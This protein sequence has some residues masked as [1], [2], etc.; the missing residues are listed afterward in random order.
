M[1][2]DVAEE[3]AS[4]CAKS[5]PFSLGSLPAVLKL[6]LSKRWKLLLDSCPTSE[7]LSSITV[8]KGPP[9]PFLLAAPPRTLLILVQ[10]FG[11]QFNI[12]IAQKFQAL[13]GTLHGC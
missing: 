10:V 7:M 8:S 6:P 4:S 1:P 12:H 9:F 11:S 2:D 5:M 13:H 3:V